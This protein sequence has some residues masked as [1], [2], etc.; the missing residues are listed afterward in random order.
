MDGWSS[1]LVELHPA[2]LN[3]VNGVEVHKMHQL[4]GFLSELAAEW[5]GWQGERTWHLTEPGLDIAARHDGGH[6]WMAWTVTDGPEQNWSATVTV[7]IEP[8]EELAALARD[9]LGLFADL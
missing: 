4:P 3:V 1:F 8:G 7:V 9:V 6:I 5:R 2:G